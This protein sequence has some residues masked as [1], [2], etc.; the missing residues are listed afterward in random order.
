MTDSGVGKV[1]AGEQWFASKNIPLL[2][3]ALLCN[4]GEIMNPT[5]KVITKID[6]K[7]R[8]RIFKRK[9]KMEKN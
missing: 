5:S 7:N 3:F 1:N 6:H 4:S 9:S 8:E 2:W